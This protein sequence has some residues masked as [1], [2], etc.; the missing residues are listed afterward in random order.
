MSGEAIATVP[1]DPPSSIPTWGTY[2]AANKLTAVT[3]GRTITF[4]R[5]IVARHGLGL[6]G[7]PEADTAFNERGELERVQLPGGL[8]RFYY[9]YDG[10]GRSVLVGDDDTGEEVFKLYA[11][12]VPIGEVSDTNGAI[13]AYTWGADGLVSMRD[14]GAS[15]SYYYHFGPQGETRK[16]TNGSGTSVADYAYSAWGIPIGTVPTVDNPYRYGGKVGYYHLNH[17]G[18]YIAGARVYHPYLMR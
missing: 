8:E 9:S 10:H 3:N 14:I 11:G 13:R 1:T 6:T 2:D 4:T 7:T 5:G 16:L 17:L 15:T 12:D 18:G